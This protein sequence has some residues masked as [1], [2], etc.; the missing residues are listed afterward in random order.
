MKRL[1][2]FSILFYIFLT[3]C[4]KNN[5]N[6]A[7]LSG[8][9]YKGTFIRTHPNAR[10]APANVSITFDSTRFSGTSDT[11][12][13][14]A[15]CSGTHKIAGQKLT[16]LNDCMFTADFDGTLIFKGEYDYELSGNELRI[17]KSYPGNMYDSYILQKQ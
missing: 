13:Y 9:V 15:I 6:N 7:A 1:L 3:A 16:V 17:T 4:N 14:P 8:T 5:I 12:N 10:F 11:R 2:A